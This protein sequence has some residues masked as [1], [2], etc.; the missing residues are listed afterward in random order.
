MNR[1]GH[2]LSIRLSAPYPLPTTVQIDAR[3]RHP[4]ESK[5]THTRGPVV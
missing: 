3:R 2:P 1:I 5:L 4:L